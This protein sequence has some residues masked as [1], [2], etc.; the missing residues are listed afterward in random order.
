MTIDQL[1]NSL[2]LAD[3]DAYNA[4]ADKY[5][6]VQYTYL[7]PN[8]LSRRYTERVENALDL[9]DQQYNA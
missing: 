1:I 2:T 7:D 9:I 6:Y 8:N 3:V 5:V 4:Q